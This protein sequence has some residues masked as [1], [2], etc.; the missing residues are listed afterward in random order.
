MAVEDSRIQQAADDGL[1]ALS[2]LLRTTDTQHLPETIAVELVVPALVS[3]ISALLDRLSVDR[4]SALR[5]SRGAI[6]V[7]SGLTIEPLQAIRARAADGHSIPEKFWH[8]W[9]ALSVPATKAPYVQPT[10][11]AIGGSPAA[12]AAWLGG[13]PSPSDPSARYLDR[14][15]QRG[16]GP[17]PSISP[18]T[19]FERAWLLCA[20]GTSKLPCDVP[21][22]LLDSLEDGLTENGAPAGAG[23]PPDSDDTAAVLRALAL[24]G[25]PQRPDVLMDFRADGYFQCF[26]GERTPSV[27]ANAHVLETLADHIAR[28]PADRPRYESALRRTASWLLDRQQREGSWR[29]KWH[30]SPVY[31]TAC[32]VLALTAYGTLAC[33]TGV[34]R[35]AEWVRCT[36]RADGGWGRWHST[37]EETSYA[38]QILTRSPFSA[39]TAAVDRGR[40]VLASPTSP[41]QHAPLWHDKDLYAPLRVIDAA[42]LASLHHTMSLAHHP[43]T[44]R[45]TRHGIITQ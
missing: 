32:C 44:R 35:A 5:R 23:L 17:V 28:S 31:A 18:I 37:A 36:Q 8:S 38:L 39:H 11:G 25:R 16:D 22:V 29:D 4:Y 14:L 27:T 10:A 13:P 41:R 30:A 33:R 45:G 24:Y 6:T 12:T 43:S 26:I 42:R 7:P 40:T 19:Y 2:R 21:S 15:Q 20:F 9:E 1:G 3:D 34:A